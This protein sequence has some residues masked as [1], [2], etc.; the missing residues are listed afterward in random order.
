MSFIARAYGTSVAE[1]KRL[2]NL[3]SDNVQLGQ[4]L[5]VADGTTNVVKPTVKNTFET[6]KD[7]VSKPT[8]VVVE[9]NNTNKVV[10][11]D[12]TY[13]DRQDDGTE[14]TETGK[15]VVS[16][17]NSLNPDRNYVLHP[18]AKIGTI[19]MITNPENNKSVF[20]R[21]VGNYVLTSGAP[22]LKMSNAVAQKLGATS[23]EFTAKIS[24]AK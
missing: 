7:T 12:N 1:I 22:V 5:L 3:T 4:K 14:I 6:I 20:A 9:T 24:Y 21:V 15:V 18:S 13:V 16:N 23:S 17:E 10:P 2:N 8:I 11:V 19:I